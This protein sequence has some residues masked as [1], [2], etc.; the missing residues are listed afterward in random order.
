MAKEARLEL[1]MRVMAWGHL[2]AFWYQLGFLVSCIHFL[3]GNSKKNV[4]SGAHLNP[5]VTIAGAFVKKVDWGKVPHY[6]LAQYLGGFLAA[7]GT[8]LVYVDA[9]NSFHDKHGATMVTAGIFATYPREGLSIWGGL[10]DQVRLIKVGIK[11]VM[12][13]FILDSRYDG[14]GCCSLRNM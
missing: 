6:I 5:A 3:F 9:F 11:Q 4:F 10:T 7:C 14:L 13:I 8:Y 12:H 2:L 1:C